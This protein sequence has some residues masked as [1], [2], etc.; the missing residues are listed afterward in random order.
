MANIRFIHDF[1]SD[2][3]TLTASTT[4][5]SLSASNMQRN[6]HAA[7]WR[8]TA[9]TATITATLAAAETVD[10]FALG[11]SN[12]TATATI[13]IRLFA[14][15]KNTNPILTINITPDTSFGSAQAWF[16]ATS[17]ERVEVEIADAG[18]SAGYI[19]ISRLCIGRRHE[20]AYNPKYGAALGYT[21]RSKSSR[22]ESGDMRTE[23]QG[24]SR[25]LAIDFDVLEQPDAEFMLGLIMR[26]KSLPLFVSLFPDAAGWKRAAHSFFAALSDGAKL[27]YPMI[28]MW[29]T[30]LVLEE[31]W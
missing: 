31:M 6:E 25:T 16:G 29:S 4:A 17:V 28:G 9:A 18:N 30:G 10:S 11:G 20:M 27:G 13:T 8:S 21:D 2:R 12:L 1:V 7:V 19:E 23:H 24:G 22:A 15:T 26:N 14:L 3:A 5:G